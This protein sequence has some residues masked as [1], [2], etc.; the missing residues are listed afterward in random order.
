MY[1]LYI[2]YTVSEIYMKPSMISQLTDEVNFGSQKLKYLT[3]IHKAGH[4]DSL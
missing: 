3:Q 1:A 4:T 2:G